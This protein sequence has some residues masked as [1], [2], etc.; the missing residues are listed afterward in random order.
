MRKT[1]LRI[2]DEVFRRV[3]IR[4]IEEDRHMET[5]VAEAI[6]DTSTAKRRR[7]AHVDRVD[8]TMNVDTVAPGR[9]ALRQRADYTHKHNA[10]SGLTVGCGSRPAYRSRSW[11]RFWPMPR[12][13]TACSIHSAVRPRR[14]SVR[15]AFRGHAAATTELNQ[16]LVWFG[17]AK[18]AQYDARVLAEAKT[19]VSF[20][21]ACRVGVARSVTRRPSITSNAGGIRLRC[22]FSGSSRAASMPPPS[23]MRPARYSSSRSAGP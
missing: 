14:R 9:S 4:A 13:I 17:R 20:W 11:T 3:K 18:T 16:F 7:A 23:A 1:T 19:A 21:L 6:T 10:A 15:A 8:T 5:V 2:P 22:C 12:L